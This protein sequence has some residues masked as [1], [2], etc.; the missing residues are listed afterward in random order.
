MKLSDIKNEFTNLVESSYAHNS[1]LYRYLETQATLKE[2]VTFL[3][4]D[5]M[6]PAFR[7]YIERWLAKTP[8]FLL[9]EI[10]HHIAEERGHSELFKTMMINLMETVDIDTAVDHEKLKALNYTFTPECVSEKEFGFFCGGFFAT[11]RMAG[12]R[13]DQLIEG[14]QRFQIP[15]SDIEFMVLH[16]A[17]ESVHSM[18]ALDDLVLPLIASNERHYSSVLDGINDRLKRSEIYLKWYE[19]NKLNI[20]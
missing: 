2:I 16:S 19:K 13:Y 8:D 17:C 20:I 7:D 18:K 11:E 9:P 6:Q 14:L 10:K 12:K 3:Y 15:K 4:W 1:Q 5:S